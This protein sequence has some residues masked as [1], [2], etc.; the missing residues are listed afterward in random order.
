MNG[1]RIWEYG[2]LAFIVTDWQRSWDG[3]TEIFLNSIMPPAEHG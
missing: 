3:G 1:R 2:A